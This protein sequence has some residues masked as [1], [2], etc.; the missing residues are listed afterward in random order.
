MSWWKDFAYLSESEK[1]FH[2]SVEAM[3]VDFNEGKAKQRKSG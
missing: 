1:D 3:S 2:V